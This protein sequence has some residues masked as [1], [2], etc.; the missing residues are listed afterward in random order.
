MARLLCLVNSNSGWRALF[1][2]GNYGNGS[3]AGL[4]YFYAN[5]SAS[6]TNSN[7]GAR[8]LVFSFD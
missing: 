3:N 4:F 2:G 7:V 5:N 1:V 8:L 6:N